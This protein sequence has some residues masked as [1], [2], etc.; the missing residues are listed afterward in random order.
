MAKRRSLRNATLNNEDRAGEDSNRVR[1]EVSE[2]NQDRVVADGVSQ[3]RVVPDHIRRRQREVAQREA[4]R[5]ARPEKR[6]VRNLGHAD[7]SKSAVSSTPFGI[8]GSSNGTDEDRIIDGLSTSEWCGPFSLARQMIAKREEAKRQREIDEEDGTDNKFHPLDEAIFQVEMERKRKVHPSLQWK[9]K[10]QN[11]GSNEK[12]NLY[13]KRQKRVEVLATGHSKVPSLFTICVKY[14]VDNFEH[15]ERL[16]TTIDSTIRTTIA[17][18]LV[19]NCKLNG[20]T[21]PALAEEGVES[22]EIVDCA[23][24]TQQDLADRL[25]VLLPAGLHYLVL[26]QAGRCVGSK[27]IQT[28]VDCL[29]HETKPSIE[30][31]TAALYALSIGGAYLLKDEDAA[32]LIAVASKSGLS[33][34]EFKACPLLGSMMLNSIR[35][36]FMSSASVVSQQPKNVLLELALE[37]LT[38]T[39]SSQ[40]SALTSDPT[41]LQHVKSLSLRRMGGLNDEIVTKLLEITTNSL[42]GLDLSDNHELT[43]NTL[44][45][46][47]LSCSRHLRAL[48]LNGLRN[49]TAAGLEATFMYVQESNSSEDGNSITSKP[50]PR[51][52][53]LD[54]ANCQHDALTDEVIHQLTLASK[55]TG[56]LTIDNSEISS[57]SL[58]SAIGGLVTLNIQGS[59]VVTD[60]SMEQLVATCA[61]TLVDLDV[62]FCPNITNQGLGYLVDNCGKQLAKIKIWGDAQISDEFLDGNK[63]VN[64]P[65]LEVIGAWMKNHRSRTMR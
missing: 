29:Q 37:D 30:T 40:V 49:L 64:D 16:G 26:D 60:A 2:T 25:Q 15:V 3:G 5:L 7:R 13:S 63:R 9:G 27:V 8:L 45:S 34:L 41:A 1:D 31:S 57:I 55:I 4:A 42:E 47:R 39:E 38:W 54:L 11:E 43:D 24:I 48:R 28:I 19:A 56:T 58:S 36:N 20:E 51:L 21:F 59:T 17:K 18:E 23:D 53:H 44:A 62:S 22:L 52:M 10:K 32:R 65:D 46:I 61:N 50:P 14:L 12:E 33:S 6:S 35:D